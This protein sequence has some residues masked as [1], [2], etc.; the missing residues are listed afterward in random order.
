MR[1]AHAEFVNVRIVTYICVI[2]GLSSL[3][4]CEGYG[5]TRA[6]LLPQFHCSEV[7]V[8]HSCCCIAILL[9]LDISY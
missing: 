9:L 6:L 4:A 7:D 3:D 8:E 2:V 1:H 5:T